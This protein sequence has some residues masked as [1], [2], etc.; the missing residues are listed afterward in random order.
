MLLN[1]AGSYAPAALLSNGTLAFGNETM[2]QTTSAQTVTMSY[3]ATSALTISGIT[4]SG[5]QSGDFSQTNSCGTSLAAGL[6]CTI[7]VTFTP[8]ATGARTAAIQIADN[9]SNSPQVISLSGTGTAAPTIGLGVLS[10]GSNSA[11]VTAGQT[12]SYTLSIGGAG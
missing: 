10:G 4:I 5:A 11:T 8:Q 9:A 1:A 2:G 7:N 12:A 6:G 3:M